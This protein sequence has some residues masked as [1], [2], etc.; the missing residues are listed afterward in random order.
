MNIADIARPDVKSCTASIRQCAQ[1]VQ[2]QRALGHL[3]QLREELRLD[4]IVYSAAMVT[5]RNAAEW[6]SAVEVSNVLGSE[7]IQTDIITC[8]T[9]VTSY[10][11]G[12]KWREAHHFL[13]H[14]R[15]R[16]MEVNVV[17]LNAALNA[18]DASAGWQQSGRILQDLQANQIQMD[19]IGLNT[20][21][22]ALDISRWKRALSYL[23]FSSMQSLRTDAITYSSAI[24]TVDWWQAGSLFLSNLQN[25]KI[26]ADTALYNSLCS[27]GWQQA[28]QILASAHHNSWRP[29]LITYNSI[30][31]ACADAEQ[32]KRAGHTLLELLRTFPRAQLISNNSM[33]SGYAKAGKW[34]EAVAVLRQLQQQQLE[35]DF[36]TFSGVIS[37]CEKA[38]QWEHALLLV[39]E[40]QQLKADVDTIVYSAAISACE[41]CGIWQLAMLFLEQLLELQLEA[42]T[43][44]C[45]AA[46]SACE[47]QAQWQQAQA[48]FKKLQA[49]NLQA[50]IISFCSLI[51][52]FEKAGQWQEAIL[53]LQQLLDQ[54][55]EANVVSF[56]AA[57]SACEKRGEWQ[58][59]RHLVNVLKQRG[60]ETDDITFNAMISS[61]E[62]GAQWP[63]AVLLLELAQM[64]SPP[65][66]ISFNATISACQK[67][68]QWHKARAVLID[69]HSLQVQADVINVGLAADV[70]AKSCERENLATALSYIQQSCRCQAVSE[71]D[72][73]VVGWGE[74]RA[75]HVP[76]QC[77]QCGVRWVRAGT[78]QSVSIFENE[79]RSRCWGCTEL[80]EFAVAWPWPAMMGPK[81]ASKASAKPSSERASVPKDPLKPKPALSSPK[82]SPSEP[83][84]PAAEPE[85][86]QAADEPPQKVDPDDLRLLRSLFHTLRL[87]M[88]TAGAVTVASSINLQALRHG[89]VKKIEFVRFPQTETKQQS[90]E[91]L[92]AVLRMHIARSEM[93][94]A[95]ASPWLPALQALA[96][97]RLALG[98]TLDDARQR[99]E[100]AAVE[101][102]RHV[103]GTTVR[104]NMD[105]EKLVLAML[106]A[107][108]WRK[109]MADFSVQ[110]ATQHLQAQRRACVA[111]REVQ[112]MRDEKKDE[113]LIR[114]IFHSLMQRQRLSE[115]A[116]SAAAQTLQQGRRS[117][118]SRRELANRQQEHKDAQLLD[119]VLRTVYLR[120]KT[121]HSVAVHSAVKLQTLQR[122]RVATIEM[123]RMREAAE[124]FSVLAPAL[125]CLV[126]RIRLA[127]LE[128]LQA[129]RKLQ[130]AL[131]VAVAKRRN[132]NAC[133]ERLQR[134]LVGLE[135]KMEAQRLL[136]KLKAQRRARTLPR[137]L[138]RVALK[139]AHLRK[140]LAEHREHHA[141]TTI[142]ARARG[143]FHRNKCNEVQN[144]RALRTII[145]VC[146]RFAVQHRLVAMQ[147]QK[148]MDDA[149]EL[150][151]SVLE[152]F[153]ERAQFAPDLPAGDAENQAGAFCP[154]GIRLLQ[155]V[156]PMLPST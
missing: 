138:M 126:L 74:K 125:R 92:Q 150:W 91:F 107:A 104:Q 34:Q 65:S 30:I 134:Y 103:R 43:A 135:K 142:Q 48:L 62:K 128:E 67:A 122:G 68:A 112:A 66:L 6:R 7:C 20:V 58:M 141:A 19:T 72:L 155:G 98:P 69:L 109:A 16:G 63:S 45:N 90:V 3:K 123:T 81:R 156:P 53:V 11:V 110:Q 117:Q 71:G 145:C 37:A 12:Q 147:Q 133:I 46:I 84:K 115:R 44:V 146:R 39:H 9:V 113:S 77:A 10:Q 76:L 116:A 95:V 23:N 57:I 100:N 139:A 21:V 28:Q 2:W 99:R 106:K 13:Q 41:K 51:S 143:G 22:S 36:V 1:T 85:Q 87:R 153:K 101:I 49:L 31:F 88:E 111:Q 52:A 82:A 29:N 105:A 151:Q 124:C 121:A 75:D 15:K 118:I 129:A 78:S 114:S 89:R 97:R 119:A 108:K 59:A 102:Q 60:I 18:L 5:C 140:K 154:K 149:L 38:G 80:P 86:P 137:S 50:N 120:V 54:N 25:Q 148:Q 79:D 127:S 61:C 56:N 24:S 26:L 8:G 94:S 14:V 73:T 4:C 32:W 55:V 93:L 40:L 131:K 35:H 132:R 144:D 42:D 130:T 33:I 70:F 64:S 152:T 27:Q 17:S 96:R 136:G 47:K 83:P